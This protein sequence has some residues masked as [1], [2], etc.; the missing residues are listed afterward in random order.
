MTANEAITKADTLRPNQIP[1]ATKTEW[2]RQLEQTVYNEIYKTHDAT[3][4]IFINLESKD[5]FW[6]LEIV[7]TNNKN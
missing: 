1:K 6:A 3:D 2:I 4:I 7:P 5:C